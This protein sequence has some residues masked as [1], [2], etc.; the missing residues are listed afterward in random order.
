MSNCQY[1]K[2][3]ENCPI[4]TDSEQ[5]Q[6]CYVHKC[7]N[8]NEAIIDK[9]KLLIF[10]GLNEEFFCT[11]IPEYE[12]LK[13]GF[14]FKIKE[15]AP[16]IDPHAFLKS[17]F[18]VNISF[19]EKAS[20][21]D[22]ERL[23]VFKFIN[24]NFEKG[25]SFK[26][27]HFPEE[28]KG[29]KNNYLFQDVTFSEESDFRQVKF[30]NVEFKDLDF[31]NCLLKD[32][33]FNNC[34]FTNVK[35]AK[36]GRIFKRRGVLYDEKK[37]VVN[38]NFSISFSDLE[39]IYRNLKAQSKANEDREMEGEFHYSENEMIMKNTKWYK[40]EGLA[41]RLYFIS[42]RFGERPSKSI[43][44]IVLIV[45]FW[46]LIYAISGIDVYKYGEF[47][48]TIKYVIS[49]PPE[50]HLA[51][52]FSL[53]TYSIYPLSFNKVVA[54]TNSITAFFALIESALLATQIGLF[55]N[56]LRRKLQR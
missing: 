3:E 21:E 11:E 55:V 27:F 18:F 6:Y 53:L 5:E 12:A 15:I 8:N 46:S 28:Y 47:E 20:F 31:S 52:I 42:S 16:K 9:D 30:N 37:G 22:F 54:P 56:A 41:K 29:F 39:K 24:C 36:D 38:N 23:A 7:I 13:I 19:L 33:V 40:P 4:E 35:W 14:D 10:L 32:A 44:N 45:F 34:R 17:L 1:S 2:N 25:C 43:W 48:R 50:I 26:N 51:D 49:L